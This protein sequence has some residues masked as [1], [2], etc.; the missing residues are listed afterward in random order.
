VILTGE[1]TT[2]QVPVTQPTGPA[3]A[4]ASRAQPQRDFLNVENITS[5]RTR[6]RSRLATHAG[7]T[8][9]PFPLSSNVANRPDGLAS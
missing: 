5:T 8:P 9:R 4:A 2:A 7:K 1:R 3:R 6:C